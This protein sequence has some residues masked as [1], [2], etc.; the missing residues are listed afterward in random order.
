[1]HISKIWYVSV[2]VKCNIRT[3]VTSQSASL[4]PRYNTGL[5]GRST[6]SSEKRAARVSLARVN[7]TL[8][9]RKERYFQ[10]R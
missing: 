10:T 7:A 6:S 2:Y 1:M 4:T 3:R 9:T 8:K 5:N